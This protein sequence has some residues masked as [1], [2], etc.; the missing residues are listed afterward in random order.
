MLMASVSCRPT[1]DVLICFGGTRSSSVLIP[2]WVL[3]SSQPLIWSIPHL[4]GKGPMGTDWDAL[5]NKTIGY[6]SLN[7]PPPPNLPL[8]SASGRSLSDDE[9]VRYWVLHNIPS[10]HFINCPPPPIFSQLVLFYTYS[11]GFPVSGYCLIVSCLIYLL[12]VFLKGCSFLKENQGEC[13]WEW[14]GLD[15]LNRQ[16]WR[17]KKTMVRCT[18]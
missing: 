3:S 4:W 5:L 9:W 8:P 16:V 18:Y 17:E 12:V 14:E 13:V 2:L 6:G 11:L 10:N 1:W 15:W 7:S